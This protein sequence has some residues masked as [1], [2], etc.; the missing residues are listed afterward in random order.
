MLWLPHSP[1]S[2]Q[3]WCPAIHVGMDLG[4]SPACCRGSWPRLCHY[5]WSFTDEAHP[6]TAHG[7]LEWF[8][9]CHCLNGKDFCGFRAPTFACKM[10][11]LLCEGRQRSL[12]MEHQRREQNWN[13]SDP[14]VCVKS[15]TSYHLMKPHLMGPTAFPQEGDIPLSISNLSFMEDPNFKEPSPR[16][17]PET[18]CGRLPSWACPISSFNPALEPGGA[19]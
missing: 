12:S 3:S 15:S 16:L 6:R 7:L 13:L 2:A 5:P 11:I 10:P 9:F 4:T 18:P 1:A 8:C 19:L 17:R 14:R